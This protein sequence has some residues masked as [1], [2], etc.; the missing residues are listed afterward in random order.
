MLRCW[1]VWKDAKIAS[2]CVWMQGVWREG[3]GSAE[4]VAVELY[5]ALL[6]PVELWPSEFSWVEGAKGELAFGE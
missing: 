2:M 6:P 1:Y 5:Q 4:L 3:E